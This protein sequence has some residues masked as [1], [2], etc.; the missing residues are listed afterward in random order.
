MIY[1]KKKPPALTTAE[2]DSD[3]WLN[4]FLSDRKL[5]NKIRML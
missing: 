2:E 1:F 5:L 3:P 4:L